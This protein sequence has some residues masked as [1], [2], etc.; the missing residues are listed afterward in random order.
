MPEKQGLP[1]KNLHEHIVSLAKKEPKKMALMACDTEGAIAEEITYGELAE[2]IE[3]AAVYLRSLGL[4][5]CDRVALAFKNS[6]ALL[7]LSWAAW[8]SGVVSVPMDTKRD[9]GEQYQYKLN[10]NKVRVLIAQAGVLKDIEGKYLKG[11]EVVDFI[12]FPEYREIVSP[13]MW[14][15]GL[16]YPSL[17]LFTSGTTGHPK[18]AMLSLENLIVNADGIRQWLKFTTDDT[19]LV[20]LPLHHINSTTFCL[21]TLLAGGTI[22]V[23]PNYSNS[24]FWQQVAG[25]G[26]TVTSIVQSIL[27]DQL[28]RGREYE[29]IKADCK[30][31]RIQIGSAPVISQ[32]VQE[33]RKK[34]GIPLYQ[35]YGQTETALRVA[36]VPMNLQE[37]LYERLVDEN[38]IGSP[39]PWADLQIS[40]ESGKFLGEGE[41][42]E[43][44]VK[45]PAIMEGYVGGESAFRDCYFLTGDIGLFRVIGG[46]KDFYLKGRKREIII[47]GGS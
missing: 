32:S 43:L 47:K 18:G 42:G 36:G 23:P 44:V 45:G 11:I 31:R 1:I 30:L 19:F 46:Q 12:G 38:S 17:V 3:A 39:M 8:A 34:Y 41:E 21:S 14:E 29:E 26:A 22:A 28:T 6:P 25:T 35:G 10:L 13:D 7:I 20:N 37:K 33:F 24:H 4:Q 27:F 2:K 9:T 15:T 5:R 40:D 16:S